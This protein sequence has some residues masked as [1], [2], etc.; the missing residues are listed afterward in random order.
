MII[1]G[2]KPEDS[3]RGK[4]LSVSYS[5]I[6]WHLDAYLN[7]VESGSKL[8]FR[9]V[10]SLFI[11]KIGFRNVLLVKEIDGTVVQPDLSSVFEMFSPV[12]VSPCLEPEFCP[13][14]CPICYLNCFLD[15]AFQDTPFPV[16]NSFTK[17]LTL[18]LAVNSF[19]L[20]AKPVCF[21]GHPTFL[22][23]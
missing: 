14:I 18:C 22:N 21:Y 20:P 15:T 5:T 17:C 13:D 3:G 9:I 10:S 1:P 12:P 19:N 2:N 11:F 16:L 4:C 23:I 6:Y 8:F 7:A